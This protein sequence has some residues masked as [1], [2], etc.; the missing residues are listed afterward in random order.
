MPIKINA[1]ARLKATQ[2]QAAK[3]SH[4]DNFGSKLAQG[5]KAEFKRLSPAK[6]EAALEYFEEIYSGEEGDEDVAFNEWR[7]AQGK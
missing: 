3:G 4:L 1:T 6:K 2:V 5:N 7:G